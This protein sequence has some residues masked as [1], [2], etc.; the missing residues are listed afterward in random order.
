MVVILAASGA[1]RCN[2]RLGLCAQDFRRRGDV[3]PSLENV[4]AMIAGENESSTDRVRCKGWP[5]RQRSDDVYSR[6]SRPRM[7]RSRSDGA[8]WA[9]L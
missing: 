6:A 5:L 9:C 1:K 2:W 7:L 3:L 8:P 4:A